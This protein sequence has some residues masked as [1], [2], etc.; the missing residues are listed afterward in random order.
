MESQILKPRIKLN[1]PEFHNHYK[2]NEALGWSLAYAFE[3]IDG[4]TWYSQF[5]GQIFNARDNKKYLPV[6]RMGDGEYSFLLQRHIYD[7]VPY[8]KL[9]WKQK[10]LKFKSF[11][12]KPTKGHSS[13]LNRD[14]K[15]Q[16][17]EDEVENL[18]K[19]YISDLK[20]ISEN[21]ILALGFDTGNF[22]GK[23]V[24][25]VYNKFIENNIT[26][27]S[28]NFYHVY[29]VYALFSSSYCKKLMNNQNVL[30]ITSV[31]EEKKKKFNIE[32]ANIG[33][34]RVDYYGI[35]ATKSMKEIIDTKNI[36]SDINLILVGAGIGSANIIK[37][38][39]E[40][41]VPCIDVGAI[42]GN[43]IDPKRK[44]ERP[45]MIPDNNFELNAIK[46][47]TDKKK[48]IVQKYFDSTDNVVK[49]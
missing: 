18:Y 15:E 48:K 13:G 45:F 10:I 46:F 19:S 32:L 31:N 4:I 20:F 21:G 40:F 44:L 9:N 28:S 47:L 29:H 24:Q 39:K 30:I 5:T 38:L 16:Y 35:S 27:H 14:G 49:K 41:K 3:D 33:V 37:Q 7:I 11:L 42:L 26:L 34:K 36:A 12:L 6:Y 25:P 22:Y 23:F 1:Y 17:T 2:I 43:F 8:S